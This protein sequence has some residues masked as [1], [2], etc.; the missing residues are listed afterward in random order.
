MPKTRIFV[1]LGASALINITWLALDGLMG[2]AQRPNP[3]LLWIVDKLGMPG[4]TIADWLA[5]SGHS[6][7]SILTGVL[8]AIVSSV[9]FYASAVWIV[10]SVP[11]WWREVRRPAP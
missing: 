8:I 2:R 10:L 11:A 5:P 4:G 6:A 7:G 9:V 3:S 1:A